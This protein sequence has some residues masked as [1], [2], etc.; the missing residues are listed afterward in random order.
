ME[1]EIRRATHGNHQIARAVFFRDNGRFAALARVGPYLVR[2]IFKFAPSSVQ[3][4]DD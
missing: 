2:I 3:L 1:K 4:G